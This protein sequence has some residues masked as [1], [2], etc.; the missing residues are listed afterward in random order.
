LVIFSCAVDP[1]FDDVPEI[2]YLSISNDTM[3]QNNLNTD[4]IFIK[5]AFKDGDGDLGTDNKLVNDNIIVTD[6]RTGV[7]A[8]RFN[9]PQIETNGLKSGIEGEITLKVFTTCCIFDDGTPP[10]SNPIDF[11]SNLIN[12]EIEMFDDNGNRSNKIVT[13][14]VTLLCQ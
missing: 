3:V 7:V 9:V 14:F 4:S 5:I 6:L 2:T 1:G 11:P 13:E 10:C 12:F 8:S